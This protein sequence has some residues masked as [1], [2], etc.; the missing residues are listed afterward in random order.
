[1]LN[2]TGVLTWLCSVN[3]LARGDELVSLRLG[4]HGGKHLLVGVAPRNL[5]VILGHELHL[6]ISLR[7][8]AR[9][10][11]A[12]DQIEGLPKAIE[13]LVLHPLALVE[14]LLAQALL[15]AEGLLHLLG[16]TRAQLISLLLEGLLRNVEA[17]INLLLLLT[18]VPQLLN[19]AVRLLLK[20][21]ELKGL[22][23][24]RF[25][26]LSKLCLRPFQYLLELLLEGL[27]V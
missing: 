4:H 7:L 26:L 18:G 6:R 9:F 17:L 11:V 23:L 2:D 22:L 19:R 16:E 24:D 13:A 27:L 12:A 15:H 21:F 8:L 5:E 3:V 20:C 10:V 1:M 14:D 25:L